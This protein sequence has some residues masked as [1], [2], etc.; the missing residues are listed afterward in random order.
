MTARH[1]EN[2][3]LKYLIKDFVTTH[4]LEQGIDNAA[5]IDVWK[6]LMGKGVN[7]YTT[8]IE[9]KHKTLYVKISSSALRE[10]LS[11]GTTKIIKMI[12]E[13]MGKEVLEAIVLR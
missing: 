10:E 2:K 1:N 3:S 5:I 8:A 4:N 9:L 6:N 7:K 13:D 12:N 11:Y